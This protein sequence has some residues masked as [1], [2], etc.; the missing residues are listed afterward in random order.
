MIQLSWWEQRVSG[1]I[2]GAHTACWRKHL[3]GKV[4]IYALR[5]HFYSK[6]YLPLIVIICCPLAGEPAFGLI[7]TNSPREALQFGNVIWRSQAKG[8]GVR[9]PVRRSFSGCSDSCARRSW[10]SGWL[11]PRSFFWSPPPGPVGGKWTLK[12]NRLTRW[13]AWA[14]NG[15]KTNTNKMNRMLTR[16]RITHIGTIPMT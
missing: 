13:S 4:W 7:K 14:V 16:P 8:A 11:H 2:Y 10:P 12:S 5:Y 3:N 6:S 15:K 1:T 9:C